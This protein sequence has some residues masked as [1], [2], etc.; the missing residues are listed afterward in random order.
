MSSLKGGGSHQ[1][2]LASAGAYLTLAV[3]M[4][5]WVGTASP[6]EHTPLP[7]AVALCRSSLSCLQQMV[8][9]LRSYREYLEDQLS[10]AKSLLTQANQ[11]IT[12]Q[13]KEL[14]ALKGAGESPEKR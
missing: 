6:Q 13:A 10:L 14:E 4:L 2:A 1:R 8:D 5:V 12:Q 7:G 3:L 9:D 11:R